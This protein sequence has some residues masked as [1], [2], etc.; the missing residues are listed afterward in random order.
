MSGKA[1][2]VAKGF[3][4]AVGYLLLLVAFVYLTFPMDALRGRIL[5]E[6]ERQ[7]RYGRP[8]TEPLMSLDIGKLDTYWL[9]GIELEELKLTIPPRVEKPKAAFPGLDLGAGGEAPEPSVLRI[10]RVHARVRLLPLL[11]GRVMIDFR[12][13]AFGGTIRGSA[14]YASEGDVEIEVEGVHLEQIAPL[15]AMVQNQ[16]LFG[17]LRGSVLLSPV[18]G[19]FAKASG[20]VDLA[21][22]NVSMFDGN[23]KLLGV[24]LPTAQ[25]GRIVLVASA[26]KGTLTIDELSVQ[27]KD[28]E[29]AGEGKIRLNESYKRSIAD[30]F[31]KFKF[32]DSYRD[33]DDATRGLLGK[34]GAK[35]KP[36]IEELDPQKT[37]VRARTDDEFY[38]FHVAGR[39]DKLD[40]QPAGQRGASRAK[41]V[42]GLGAA[43]LKESRRASKLSPATTPLSPPA[44]VE[45]PPA[46]APEPP[47]PAAPEPPPPAAAPVELDGDLSGTGSE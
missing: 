11:A 29:L 6:F 33:K 41:P 17:T 44:P 25:I 43:T 34:P 19:K 38:R 4:W 28:V 30:L 46:A 23:S 24:A 10:D 7:Q 18:D 26:D 14:P 35:F 2:R 3:G 8:S 40:V 39:L 36:A 37:F 21:V 20:K 22:D 15:R 13:E 31:V 1:T 32:T 27:G 47:P 12:A 16:P 45:P 5:A 9:S 42:G